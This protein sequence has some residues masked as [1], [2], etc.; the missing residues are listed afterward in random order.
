MYIVISSAYKR[1]NIESHSNIDTCFF[2]AGGAKV[3]KFVGKF[4]FLW[5]KRSLNAVQSTSLISL[6][7]DKEQLNS[8]KL[9]VYLS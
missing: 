7:C 3:R 1:K 6:N 8:T 2:N 5:F 4:N 9:H